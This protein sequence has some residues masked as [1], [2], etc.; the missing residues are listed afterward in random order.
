M[1]ASPKVYSEKR[2]RTKRFGK[3]IPA[4]LIALSALSPATAQNQGSYIPPAKWKHSVDKTEVKVGDVITLTLEAP[5]PKG[6][7]IYSSDFD[8][9]CG[10][11]V[12]SLELE[13]D[14]SFELKGAMVAHGAEKEYDDV[15][16]CD[17]KIFHDKAKFTQKIK[18]N[19]TTPSISGVLYYQMCDEGR[20]VNHEYAFDLSNAIKVSE[21]A[22]DSDGGTIFYDPQ[23]RKDQPQLVQPYEDTVKDTTKADCDCCDEVRDLLKAQKAIEDATGLEAKFTPVPKDSVYYSSYRGSGKGDTTACERKTFEGATDETTSRGLLG[24]FFL[25][26][27]AGL[28]ALL[29]PCVFPMIPMTVSFFMKDSENRA[30]AIR[31]GIIYGLS[32]IAIYTLAGTLVSVLVGPSFANWLSTAW[33]PN[34]LFFIIFVIFA[35]SFFGAFE[36]VLPSG[37]V[38]RMNKRSDR[39][40]LIG[41]FFM[42]FTIVLVSFSCTGPIV[43][44]ILVESFGGA[45]IRPVVGMLGFSLAFA[46]PFGLFAIFPSMLNNLPKSGGWLNSVKVVLGFLE[47]ALGLKFLSVADQTYHWGILDREIYIGLWIV[48]FTLMGI[49]LLGKIKFAHDSDLPHIKVPR[50]FMAIA[51]FA[52]VVYLIPGLWGA[53]LKALAGYLPPMHTHDFNLMAD[54]E[55]ETKGNCGTA[56]YSEKLHLPYNLK[57]YFDYEQGM[58]CARQITRPVFVDFTGHG[59]VNCREMEAR[60]W[61]DPRVQKI[62]DEEYVVIS[63]YVDDKTIKLP[64]EEHYYSRVKQ[65]MVRDLAGKNSDIQECYFGTNAQPQYVLLDNYGELLAP[66]LAYDLDKEGYLKFLKSGVEMYEKRMTSRMN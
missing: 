44:T 29:T 51:T 38:N 47:L 32:I 53:P 40:G 43:G 2:N 59:C 1:V 42:A 28:L 27:A 54:D 39:G 58:E 64:E 19:S 65:R 46:I 45:I 22:G 50:F 4:L 62:L 20:C 12:T 52:F 21:S 48:I 31:K 9:N 5:I 36:L 18:I 55:G 23:F 26:F 61:S 49:Y 14:P 7:H 35:I 6:F 41:I 25:A 66:T 63:L 17:V 13:T 15:F 16:K 34:V 60:V 30:M 8:P 57:G 24:F 10:P 3:L 37:I 33:L 56:L 11:I